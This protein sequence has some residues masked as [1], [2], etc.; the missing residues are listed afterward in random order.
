VPG[1]GLALAVQVGRQEDLV[2]LAGKLAQL[3]DDLA[4]R[5]NPRSRTQLIFTGSSPAAFAARTP[6]S[7]AA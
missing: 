2:A 6:A 4:A 7:T 5:V 1:D 3:L